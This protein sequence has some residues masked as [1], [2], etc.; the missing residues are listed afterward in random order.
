MASDQGS[1]LT[2]VEGEVDT[3]RGEITG[4]KSKVESFGAIL[5]RI[6]S[7]IAQASQQ[8][9][10]D[11][12]ASKINPV[13]LAT[14]LVTI[15]TGMMAGSWLISAELSRHDERSMWQQKQIDRIEQRQWDAHRIS[16]PS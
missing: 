12:K 7:G 9:A 5:T 15:I 4:L 1:R 11:K 2:R 16:L 6:E 13:A 14:V 3:I 8:A 10:D